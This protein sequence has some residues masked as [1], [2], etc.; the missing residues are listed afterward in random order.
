MNFCPKLPNFSDVWLARKPHIGCSFA[1]N[2]RAFSCHQ[3]IR[4][5][6]FS[7][8]RYICFSFPFT[9]SSLSLF[10]RHRLIALWNED[11]HAHT[12]SHHSVQQWLI[13]G[14]FQ[15]PSTWNLFV[16]RFLV[17]W[18]GSC[19]RGPRVCISFQCLCFENAP[20]LNFLFSNNNM[21]Q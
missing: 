6:S 17:I 1:C 20:C 5:R 12:H 11:T 19:S 2:W 3:L 9:R 4:S 8:A 13:D 16:F 18:N 21:L 10:S 14:G 7:F 15:Q